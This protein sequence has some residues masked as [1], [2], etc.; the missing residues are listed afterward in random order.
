MPHP[1]LFRSFHKQSSQKI[2]LLERLTA[3][4]YEL[5]LIE[6][7]YPAF[8]LAKLVKWLKLPFRELGSFADR[9]NI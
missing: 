5:F 8:K 1:P 3:Y 4:S 2:A 9:N 7:K 6:A